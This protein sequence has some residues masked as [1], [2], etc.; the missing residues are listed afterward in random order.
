MDIV[1]KSCGKYGGAMPD[2]DGD[3]P[4]GFEYISDRDGY[5]NLWLCKRCGKKSLK[6]ALAIEKILGRDFNVSIPAVLGVLDGR[7]PERGHRR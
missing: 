1:C 4:S 6:H 5:D 3:Y 7:P 2:R